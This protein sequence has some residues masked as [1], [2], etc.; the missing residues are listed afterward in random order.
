MKVKSEF[1]RWEF[2]E[3]PPLKP[4]IYWIKIEPIDGLG[5][6]EWS[7]EYKH[8]PFTGELCFDVPPW[9]KITHWRFL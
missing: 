6:T 2:L 7:S 3:T 8:N 4:G 9:F 1:N 5:Q